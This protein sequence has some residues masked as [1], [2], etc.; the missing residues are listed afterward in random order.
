MYDVSALVTVISVQPNK[1]ILIEWPGRN[2]PTTVEWLFDTLDDAS[3]FVTITDSG[4]AGTGDE[5]VEQAIDSTGG[6]S[7]V[8]AGAKALLEHNIELNL[9]ADRHPRG[10]EAHS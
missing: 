10:I 6:F 1:R 9:V 2:G 8:L 5:V 4:F 7:L 3:T